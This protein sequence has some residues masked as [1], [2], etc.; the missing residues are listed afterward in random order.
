MPMTRAGRSGD[1]G[2][3]GREIVHSADLGS[4][5]EI[6]GAAISPR[7]SKMTDKPRMNYDLRKSVGASVDGPSR[8]GTAER[9]TIPRM[10]AG[11]NVSLP[12]A[13]AH[14][15]NERAKRITPTELARRLLIAGMKL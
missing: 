6:P 3:L 4:A 2:V 13:L 1:G 9:R 8:P 14:V 10:A 11:N 15:C 5:N 12:K 7:P